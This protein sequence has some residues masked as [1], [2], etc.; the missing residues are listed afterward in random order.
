MHES[1]KIIAVN[2]DPEAPILGIAHYGIIGDL[3]DVIPKLI[4]AYKERR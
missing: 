3:N 4:K 2:L 1:G